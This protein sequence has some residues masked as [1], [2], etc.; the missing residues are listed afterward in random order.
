MCLTWQ[1][2]IAVQLIPYFLEI[3]PHLELSPPS[4]SR[5]IVL[6]LNALNAALEFSPH[7]VKGRHY[8]CTHTYVIVTLILN[9]A[10]C[11]RSPI[12]LLVHVLYYSSVTSTSVAAF[13]I[14]PPSKCRRA[15]LDHEIKC[16]LGEISRKYGIS[17]LLQ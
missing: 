12:V 5:R 7:V 16:R 3:S 9:N 13:E 14:W 10:Q 17:Y 11:T 6:T 4:K 1:L 15:K 8:Y 2:I